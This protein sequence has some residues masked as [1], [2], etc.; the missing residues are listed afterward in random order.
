MILATVFLAPL[1]GL[2]LILLL[3]QVEQWAFREE[4]PLRTHPRSPV[5]NARSQ[6]RPTSV[7]T[8]L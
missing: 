1:V 4:E 5:A 7:G 3:E 8:V 2:G 6:A